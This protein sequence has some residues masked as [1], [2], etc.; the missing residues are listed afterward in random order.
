M[1]AH[2]QAPAEPFNFAPKPL[3]STPAALSARKPNA[4]AAPTVLVADDDPTLRR[5]VCE[6]LRAAGLRVLEADD[7]RSAL[8]TAGH[9]NAPIDLLVTDVE[10]PHLDGPTLADKLVHQRPGLPVLFVSALAEVPGGEQRRPFTFLPKPFRLTSL[11]EQVRRLLG[12]G[13]WEKGV[14]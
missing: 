8:E 13:P 12:R 3:P 9:W 5:L 14:A 6:A 7:G 1:S 11:L 4:P 2:L 10:M